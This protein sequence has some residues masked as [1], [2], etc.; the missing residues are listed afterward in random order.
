MTAPAIVRNVPAPH[1]QDAV[2]RDR[3][4]GPAPGPMGERLVL[5]HFRGRRTG[6]DLEVIAGLHRID[7]R[8]YIATGSRW[9]H[10][11]AGGTPA[12][13]TWRGRRRPV[14]LRLVESDDTTTAGYARLISAYGRTDAE[15]RLGIIINVE[16]A[17]TGEEVRDAVRRCG[18]S[19]VE[20]LLEEE[21]A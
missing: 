14:E 19:L 7:D 15:R 21:S 3:L 2:I 13:M 1:Q 18:L 11:F 10:N 9:R 12:A 17:P 20:V 4:A 5:L 6:R 16:R 8:L